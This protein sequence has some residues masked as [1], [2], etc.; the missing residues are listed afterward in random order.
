LCCCFQVSHHS[1]LSPNL[2]ANAA[3]TSWLVIWVMVPA[4]ESGGCLTDIEFFSSSPNESIFFHHCFLRFHHRFALFHHTPL[5]SHHT[6]LFFHHLLTTQRKF[7]TANRHKPFGSNT[8]TV[9][10]GT[11]PP[12][13]PH[14]PGPTRPNPAP[15]RQPSSSGAA[16][17]PRQL[18]VRTLSATSVASMK[19]QKTM[20]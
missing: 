4:K 6:P 19:R 12:A 5:Y 3:V 8:A 10:L 15:P 2:A 9:N 1:N 7:F 14:P 16:H 20:R 13:P 17:A 18:H 11:S